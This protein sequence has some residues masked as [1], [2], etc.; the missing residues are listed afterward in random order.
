MLRLRQPLLLKILL[1]RALLL[2]LHGRMLLMLFMLLL[3]KI[4]LLLLLPPLLLLMRMLLPKV[5]QQLM[6]L[7]WWCH[8]GSGSSCICMEEC[9]MSDWASGRCS[10]WSSASASA[11]NS[12]SGPASASASGTSSSCCCF[13]S[14]RLRSN[15]G[16]CVPMLQPSENS[17]KKSF[18][19]QFVRRSIPLGISVDPSITGSAGLEG[20]LQLEF[21]SSPYGIRLY[22]NIMGGPTPRPNMAFL[23]A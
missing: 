7:L 14:S 19:L 21:L 10:W 8:S 20:R 15:Y 22:S 18:G 4:L 16:Q 12:A 2:L 11:A 17:N 23:L 3:Q 1:Q 9:Q 13:C 5:S 6:L